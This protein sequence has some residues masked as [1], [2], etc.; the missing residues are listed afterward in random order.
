M[1][2]FMGLLLGTIPMVLKMHEDMRITP[3]RVLFFLGG[4]VLV[5]GLRFLGQPEDHFASLSATRGLL[6]NTVISFL[7]GGAS[8]TPGLD[9]SYV[10]LVGGTYGPIIEAVSA[11]SSLKI[12]WGILITTG[13]GAVLG[14][15]G[16]SKLIDTA[17]KRAAAPAYFAIL[18]L[19][20]G[21]IYGLWPKVAAREGP[22][23]LIAVF[24]V[25]AAIAVLFGGASQN[26]AGDTE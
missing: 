17:I 20:V 23:V 7:A 5:V 9:G 6:Y 19:I 8:V 25:G 13:V 24:I 11:L 2:F 18:G 12:Q 22:V 1:F 3:A 26:M 16:F 4:I 10:L 21:S 14:I 15:A